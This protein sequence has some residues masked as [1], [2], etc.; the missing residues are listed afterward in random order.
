MSSKRKEL[1]MDHKANHTHTNSIIGHIAFFFIGT[2]ALVS[3]YIYFQNRTAVTWG[4]IGLVLAHILATAGIL[5]IGRN[6]FLRLIHK[7]HGTDSSHAHSHGNLDTEGVTLSWASTYDVFVRGLFLGQERKFRE[8]IV[9]LAQIQPGE[10]VLDVGCGTGT[11]A[12]MARLKS[13]PTAQIYGRDA[14]PQM[15]ER[16]RQKAVK[17]GVVVDFQTGLVEAIDAP[18]NTFDLVLSSFMVHHLPGDLKSKAFAEIYRVLKPGGRLI[19]VD[20]EPPTQGFN[21][22][23]FTLL[24]GSMM[25]IDNR[26]IP[27]L[28]KKAGFISLKTGVAGS[29]LATFI[30]GSKPVDQVFS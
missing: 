4:I 23:F 27:P 26:Q 18:D 6:L 11:L 15:V 24:L 16:A 5:Y 10:K 29:P 25:H 9:E 28:L 2:I 19:V 8:A 22:I 17:A 20:F 3:L 30:L 12:I 7:F 21:K 1:K 14:S 13:H